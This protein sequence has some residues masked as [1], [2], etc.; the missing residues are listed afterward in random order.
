MLGRI[1]IPRV[2]A[3]ELRA[4]RFFAVAKRVSMAR[5]F[6]SCRKYSI[7]PACRFALL[8]PFATASN[9]RAAGDG[10]FNGDLGA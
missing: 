9:C 3:D 8:S 4:G 5:P 2:A 1:Q 6:A 7:K 10:P